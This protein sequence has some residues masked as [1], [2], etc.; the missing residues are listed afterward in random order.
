MKI[1]CNRNVLLEYINIVLKAVSNR[2]TLPILECILLLADETGF[3]LIGNDLEMGIET[4]QITAEILETGS[5]ALDSKIFSDIIRRLPGDMVSISSDDKNITLIKS[6]KSEFKIL[7][8]NG[9]E[10]PFLPQVEKDSEYKILSKDLKDM[11]RQTI[12]SVAIND[13]KAVMTGELL[14]IKENQIKMVAVDGFRISLRVQNIE[15]ENFDV[16]CVIPAKTLN[17][18][19]KLFNNDETSSISIYFTSKHIL[20]EMDNCIIISRLLEG[21]FIN[22]ENVFTDEYTT[23]ITV[24]RSFLLDSLE[25]ASLISKDAKK[26]PVKLNISADMLVITSNTEAGTSYEEIPIELDGIDIEIAFNP[27]Y[28]IDALKIIEDEKITMQFTTPLSPCIMRGLETDSYKYLVL[29][30]RLKS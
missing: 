27:R 12:F 2:T 28:L 1:I 16:K 8:Q 24:D 21:D 23:L 22:Y 4:K 17:E 26:N 29:P 10:F 6:D 30:L 5:I 19:S 7:G 25:R 14:E 13:S 9:D 18:L 15:T 11:I 3:R 20:F